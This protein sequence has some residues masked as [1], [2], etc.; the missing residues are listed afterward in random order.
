[1]FGIVAKEV[2]NLAGPFLYCRDLRV[3]TCPDEPHSQDRFLATASQPQHCFTRG[4]EKKSVARPAGE[5]LDLRISL[6]LVGLEAERQPAVVLNDLR[7]GRI[8]DSCYCVCN[9]VTLPTLKTHLLSST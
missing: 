7:V 2:V 8:R 5:K 3:G 4:R 6:A 9:I 1:M